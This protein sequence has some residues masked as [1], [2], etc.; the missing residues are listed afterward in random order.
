MSKR[1]TLAEEGA[2]LNKAVRELFDAIAAALH[3]P[4]LVEWINRRLS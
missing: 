2:E 3:L 1:K 4:Q